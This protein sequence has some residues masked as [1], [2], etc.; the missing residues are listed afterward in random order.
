[1]G[2][3]QIQRERE[4]GETETLAVAGHGCRRGDCGM[5]LKLAWTL[6]VSLRPGHGALCGTHTQ[7]HTHRQMHAHKQI[8]HKD[9]RS[10]PKSLHYTHTQQAETERKTARRSRTHT[11]SISLSHTRGGKDGWTSVCVKACACV[12]LIV[13][14]LAEQNEGWC[15]RAA[16]AANSR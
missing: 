6:S 4:R 15:L 14:A 9:V 8:K 12:C 10:L 2:K 5:Q 3:R 7:T 11:H 1:M 13:P 16:A